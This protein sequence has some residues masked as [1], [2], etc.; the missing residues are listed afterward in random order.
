MGKSLVLAEKPSVARELAR[1][2]GCKGS[3]DGFMEGKQYIVTWALGHLVTLADPDK[4]DKRWEK[5]EME[6]LPMMPDRMKLEVIRQSSRQFNAVKRLLERP[7]VSDIVIATDAGREGE[8][9]ARWI[10]LKAGCKKPAKRLWISSH[11]D[12]SIKEGF[13]KLRPSAEYDNLF[14]S[15]Q[16]RSHAD[17]LVGLNVTRALTCKYNAQLSAGRVQTPTLALIV[18]R[19]EEIRAFKPVPFSTVQI[20][21]D[22]FTATLQ[23]EGGSRIF[24]EKEAERL[25]A[26]LK[27]AVATVKSVK[28]KENIVPPPPAFDLTQ[29]QREA[30]KKWAY[31]AK[32]T[33][34]LCQS[35]YERHKVLTYPR[36]DSRYIPTDVVPSLRER[37]LAINQGALKETVSALLKKPLQTK[38]LVNDSKVTDHHAIIPTE[39]QVMLWDLSGAEKNIY[40][41]ACRQFVGTL[42]PPCRYETVAVV[43]TAAGETF[44]AKFRIMKEAGWRS[45]N[46]CQPDEEDEPDVATAAAAPPEGSRLNVRS[47]NLRQGKTSP[48]ARYTEASLL[49][50]ME[51]PVG[52]DGKAITGSLGTPAT[53]AEIIDRL[54]TAFYAERRGRE[55]VPTSKGKQLVSLAPA[56]LRSA[57]LTA[58][59]EERLSLIAS[60]KEKDK[61]FIYDIRDFTVKL[62]KQVQ[63]D[64]GKY[65]HDNATRQ[66]CPDCGAMLLRVKGKHGEMLICSDRQCG[67]HKSISRQ[68]NARCP[69]CHKKMELRGTGADQMFACVCGYRE[70]LSAFKERTATNSA[71]K[72]DVRRYLDKQN[73]SR[74][75]GTSAMAAQLAKWLEKNKDE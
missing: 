55:I 36:T 32:E 45:T 58:R 54:F 67:Y 24:D 38:Y 33:L 75:T 4:Y 48:P 35:L 66:T 28:R 65:V 3:G 17:W 21:L 71:G 25:A 29:L 19:E 14:L 69:N 53:R 11:T 40:E 43:L 15:A 42:L 31:T 10:L 52:K 2:L 62:V 1:V 50:A 30:N 22:G 5:W 74:D 49:A 73:N 60:G 13:A 41:L 23:R 7:D 56:Q 64:D 37:L 70:K 34:D 47:V 61:S 46:I 72:A 18:K 20:E 16:A 6:T 44:T 26:K 51:H 59:W 68:T 12:K 9:V 57:E 27:G 39:E 63:M 8:L